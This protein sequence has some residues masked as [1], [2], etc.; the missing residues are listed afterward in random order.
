[1]NRVRH[2]FKCRY[3]I[4][5]SSM[6]NRTT[7]LVIRRIKAF[8][9]DYLIILIY[10]GLLTGITV[11][12][13]N[14]FDTRPGKISTV[15]AELIGFFTL[16]LPVILYFAISEAGPHAGTIGKQ[17]FGLKVVSVSPATAGFPR[18]LLRNLIKFLPWEIAHFFIYQ[19]FYYIR[20][21]DP[22]PGWVVAGLINAQVLALVYLLF[23]LFHKDNR[24]LYEIASGTRVVNK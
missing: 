10:I 11:L 8:A 2:N 23:I 4:P 13:S 16:T 19:L 1:M 20:T 18:L 7:S 22:P 24:S 14:L 17:K 21:E 6:N 5:S 12:I 15:T 9:I 3:F